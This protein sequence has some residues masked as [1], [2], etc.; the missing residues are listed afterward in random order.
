MLR[1]LAGVPWVLVLIAGATGCQRKNPEKCDEAQKVA[2]QSAE[3]GDFALVR[4]WREYA[5]KH[6][7]DRAALEA[8]DREITAKEK[9]YV[10]KKAADEAKQKEIDQLVQVFVDWASQH[11]SNPAGAGG[12]APCQ[13]PEDST[14]RWCVRQRSVS[15]LY[16]LTARYWEAEPAA[17]QFSLRAPG[18]VTCD[19]LGPATVKNT[20]SGGARTHC[21]LTGGLLA[22][23]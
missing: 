23:M 10:T 8:L 16:P 17:A 9:A 22:G 14:D 4:Q 21:D 11:K 6:C 12:S 18:E 2:R 19:K 13:G 1:R 5:Y 3:V 15:G 20:L 7:A